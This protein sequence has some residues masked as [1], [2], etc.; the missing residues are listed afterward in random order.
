ME[1]QGQLAVSA[2]KPVNG[3]MQ[4][5]A[6]LAFWVTAAINSPSTLPALASPLKTH[7]TCTVVTKA[8]IEAVLGRSLAIG[9]EHK[10][11]GQ[12]TCDYTE[13]DGGITIALLHST[14]KLDAE[15]EVA[16]L[17]KL[18]PEGAVR[19]ANGFGARAYFVDIPNAGTQFYV[20]RG[21]H[22][23]LMISILGFGGPAQVSAAAIRIARKALDRL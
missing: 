23:Y 19:D 5:L 21:D 10:G 20:L 3:A 1:Y 11:A 18:L 4:I 17:R 9:V 6:P 8:E 12:S 7:S 13:G 22:D 14:D 2:S 16:Y 15:V